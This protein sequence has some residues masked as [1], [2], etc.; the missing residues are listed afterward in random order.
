MSVMH[1]IQDMTLRN[2]NENS[3]NPTEQMDELMLPEESLAK[4]F[5]ERREQKDLEARTFT[6]EEMRV[7]WAFTLAATQDNHSAQDMLTAEQW[8]IGENLFQRLNEYVEK[9]NSL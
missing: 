3:L 6:P 7:L 1:E 4:F 9:T 5:R 8:E 2:G